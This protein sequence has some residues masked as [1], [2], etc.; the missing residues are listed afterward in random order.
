MYPEQ[1][2]FIA[3]LLLCAAL[4]AHVADE[5]STG[6]LNLKNRAEDKLLRGASL[7]HLD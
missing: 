4:V 6:F 5:A 1:R 3:W 7:F 2:C